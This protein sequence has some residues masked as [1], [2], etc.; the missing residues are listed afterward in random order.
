M[1]FSSMTSL[2]RKGEK[3]TVNIQQ[4]ARFTSNV[5]NHP[6]VANTIMPAFDSIAFGPHAVSREMVKDVQGPNRKDSE[7]A[8]TRDIINFTCLPHPSCLLLVLA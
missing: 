5:S 2:A 4:G 3:F 7:T 6:T 8:D 1:F